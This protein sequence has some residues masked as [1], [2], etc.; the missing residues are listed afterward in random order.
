MKKK[1]REARNERIREMRENDTTLEELQH[2]T[3]L[4]RQQLWR[5]LL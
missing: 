1:D 3:G 4:T 2:L 5:I